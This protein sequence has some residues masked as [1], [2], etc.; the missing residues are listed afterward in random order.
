MLGWPSPGQAM[1]TVLIIPK[2]PGSNPG[3]LPRP[4]QGEARDDQT[5]PHGPARPA[6]RPRHRG[7]AGSWVAATL[8]SGK[9][10]IP[11]RPG[12]RPGQDAQVAGGK[13]GAGPSARRE[14]KGKTTARDRGS[15]E[16][17][18]R[19]AEERES[20]EPAKSPREPGTDRVD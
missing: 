14:E 11:A 16:A 20:P 6:G 19:K 2:R 8:S 3:G 9:R 5:A 13:G 7:P 4:S 17:P 12:M 1:S 10:I 15:A 18:V